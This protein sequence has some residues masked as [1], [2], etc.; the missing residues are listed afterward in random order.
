MNRQEAS[1]DDRYIVV[2]W[3]GEGRSLYY[4]IEQFE[5]EELWEVAACYVNDRA[6]AERMARE[7]NAKWAPIDFPRTDREGT[8]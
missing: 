3:N 4:V 5:T 7:E 8:K 1:M 2:L 6:G